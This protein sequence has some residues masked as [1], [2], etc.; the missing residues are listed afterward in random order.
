VLSRYRLVG[1]GDHATGPA[2]FL[3]GRTGA[4]LECLPR[5]LIPRTKSVVNLLLKNI[6]K[7]SLSNFALFLYFSEQHAQKFVTYLQ[8]RPCMGVCR[9]LEFS[10]SSSRIVDDLGQ[11]PFLV[12]DSPPA[13]D[14]YLV[15]YL[16]VNYRLLRALVADYCLSVFSATVG[17][18]RR[19]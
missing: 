18:C 6:N 12:G 2:N 11:I 1:G 3:P 13:R 7:F 10:Y 16:S 14:M 4:F 8:E 19:Y 17:R 5:P 15:N 9:I